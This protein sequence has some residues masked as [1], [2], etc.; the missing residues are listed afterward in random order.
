MDN[1]TP[2]KG[3]L[4]MPLWLNCAALVTAQGV[5]DKRFRWHI[6]DVAQRHCRGR[7]QRLSASEI[8]ETPSKQLYPVQTFQKHVVSRRFLEDRLHK[9]DGGKLVFVTR[10]EHV[11]GRGTLP[12]RPA[13]GPRRLQPRI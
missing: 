6:A 9:R 11:V 10:P 4:K 2:G 7:A 8:Y 3:L 12:N 13:D 1:A 5:H